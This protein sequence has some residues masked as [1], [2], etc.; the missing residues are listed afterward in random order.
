[1]IDRCFSLF[2]SA[3]LVAACFPCRLP[4]L[5]QQL[6]F[7]AIVTFTKIKKILDFPL[8]TQSLCLHFWWLSKIS[9]FV[10]APIVI[11]RIFLQYRCRGIH[12]AQPQS[13]KKL[14]KG[15]H[16]VHF[17]GSALPKTKSTANCSVW[18]PQWRVLS[19]KYTT[20]CWK[21]PSSSSHTFNWP[22]AVKSPP[23]PDLSP[24]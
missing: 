13:V 22:K 8:P 16:C 23:Q 1:M 14:T 20:K 10:K 19:N 17:T 2:Q 7:V 11:R 12:I 15:M 4:S 9:C 21:R 18:T 6:D 24:N 5:S 3:M